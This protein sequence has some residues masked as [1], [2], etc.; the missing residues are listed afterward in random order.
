[1]IGIKTKQGIRVSRQAE[2]ITGPHE[3]S[4]SRTVVTGNSLLSSFPLLTP[5]PTETILALK[6]L[7]AVVALRT[8][9]TD[10]TIPA[11]A[12]VLAVKSLQT[13]NALR[14]WVTWRAVRSW[15]SVVRTDED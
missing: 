11:V 6:T 7:S 3:T 5:E 10:A 13:A 9:V 15:R 1:L 12:A 2:R 14:S 8:S 4:A